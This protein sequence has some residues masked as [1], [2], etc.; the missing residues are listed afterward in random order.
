MTLKYPLVIIKV[1]FLN[2]YPRVC[3]QFIE[4]ILVSS[5]SHHLNSKL[6]FVNWKS[7][8][9]ELTRWH[10]EELSQKP[11]NVLP[12]YIIG[13]KDR[14]ITTTR[15]REG[16]PSKP[17]S[18]LVRII[19]FISPVLSPCL[20]LITSTIFVRKLFLWPICFS[21]NNTLLQIKDRLQKSIVN[22]WYDKKPTTLYL[23]IYQFSDKT[24]VYNSYPLLHKSTEEYS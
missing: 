10:N 2:L 16:E 15:W 24:P 13:T 12:C 22:Y 19:T 21:H 1:K 20:L 18:L 11:L 3:L 5:I 6:G 14:V 17:S 7:Q 9:V 23:R 4:Q 8:V